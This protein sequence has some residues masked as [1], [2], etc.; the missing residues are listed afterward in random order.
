MGERESAGPVFTASVQIKELEQKALFMSA[1]GWR[2]I[3]YCLANSYIIEFTDH[4]S[5][6]SP[7][8]WGFRCGMPVV[9]EEFC[10]RLHPVNKSMKPSFPTCLL[11]KI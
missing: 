7:C 10:D 3:G 1:V 6:K 11:C 5:N 4:I 2:T 9:C 8:L